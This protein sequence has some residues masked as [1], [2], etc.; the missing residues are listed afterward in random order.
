MKKPIIRDIDITEY[1][2]Q[3]CEILAKGLEPQEALQ[4]LLDFNRSV[5]IVPFNKDKPTEAERKDV[6]E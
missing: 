6:V 5:K 3:V 1:D 2:R 4:A